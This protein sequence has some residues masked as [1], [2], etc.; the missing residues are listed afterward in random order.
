MR[1]LRRSVWVA[2]LLA[3]CLV[4][5]APTLAGSTT[6][7]LSTNYT[8]VNLGDGPA[9]GTIEYYKPDGSAWGTGSESFTINEPGGQAIFR[10]YF[11]SG[12]PGNPGLT[13][14]TGSVVVYADQ[15]I[16]A[17][18]Q[19]QARDQNPTSM[20]AYSGVSSGSA[21]FYVPLAARVLSTASGVANSQ[22]IAQNTY[23]ASVDVSFAL[24]SGS[25][26][27]QTY[28]HTATIAEGASHTYDLAD[29]ISSNVPNNWYGSVVVSVVGSGE[30][31]VVS[32]YFIGDMLQTF[33]G[34]ATSSAGTKWHVPLFA[35]RLANTLSTPLAVQN[36]S[37]QTIPVDGLVVTLY[38]DPA[39]GGSPFQLKNT[40]T[41]QPYGAYYFNPR[42][43]MSIPAGFYGAAVVEASENVVAFVQMALASSGEAAAYEA[44]L[45]GTGGT[46]V[47][48]PLVAKR[49]ANGLATAVT[50]Q[51]LTDQPATVNLRYIPGD[52]AYSEVVIQNVV[53][54]P[55]RSLIQNHRVEVPQLPSGW[56]G[57]LVVTSDQDIHAFVQLSMMRSI[58]P[59]VPSGDN[60]MAHTAFAQTLVD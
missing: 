6:K 34:F 38:P 13:N 8:L 57:S 50:I 51:N 40:T 46:K 12:T 3:L 19:V 9:T 5:G 25:T 1:C 55:G 58:N 42:V 56:Y 11:A 54:Q 35:S 17:V 26:G 18:V 39:L 43:D 47:T 20:G 22:I 16:G 44:I 4:V 45:D 41:I 36:V 28:E 52:A 33:N 14:G 48:V 53:I 31:A 29:E 2:A 24:I 21:A 32:N 49:L 30:V 23:T 27:A 15:P 10:Q 7:S 60:F 37:D 59:G